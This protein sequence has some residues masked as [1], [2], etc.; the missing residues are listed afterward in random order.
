MQEKSTKLI[1]TLGEIIMRHRL[2]T[3]KSIYKIS[4]E[5]SVTKATWRR[6]ELGFHKDVNLTSLWKIAEGLEISPEVLIK[7]LKENLG[8]NFSLIDD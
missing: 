6:I 3:G 4:A 5:S 8:A 1:K 7:E 2:L